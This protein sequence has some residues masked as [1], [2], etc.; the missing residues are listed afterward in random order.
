M[1]LIDLTELEKMYPKATYGLIDAFISRIKLAQDQ[2]AYKNAFV[3]FYKTTGSDLL[4]G[5]LDAFSKYVT[6]LMS[7]RANNTLKRSTVCK[8]HKIIASFMSYCV[9]MSEHTDTIPKNFEN[10]MLYFPLKAPMD[11]FQLQHV[12]TLS[13][14]DKL[15]GYLKAHDQLTLIA[16]LFS[17]RCYLKTGDFINLKTGDVFEQDGSY[18]VEAHSR[19]VVIPVPEDMAGVIAE[20]FENNLSDGDYI[21]SSKRSRHLAITSMDVRLQKACDACGISYTFNDIRNAAAVYS[22]SNGASEEQISDAMGYKT[23]AH[24]KKLSSLKVPMEKREDY[25]NICLK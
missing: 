24:I 11:I 20:H 2:K 14:L 19:G 15:I 3:D 10:K 17:L 5:D 7:L 16:V 23:T 18:F 12:P 21:F 25:I 8:Y 9:D 13:E 1:A 4:T 22:A 6:H